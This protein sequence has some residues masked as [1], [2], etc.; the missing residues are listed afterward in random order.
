VGFRAIAAMPQHWVCHIVLVDSARTTDTIAALRHRTQQHLLY[1]SVT[2]SCY[3][4]STV[5][6]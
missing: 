6:F 1:T 5:V 3:C 4:Y 2:H